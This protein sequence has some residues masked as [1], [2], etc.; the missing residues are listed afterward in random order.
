MAADC[1]G[2]VLIIAGS[3]PSGGAGIQAD[4]KTVT[5]LGGYASAAVSALTVQNTVGVQDVMAVPSAFVAGQITA[6]LDDIGA[7]VVKT[8]MLFDAATI[9]AVGEAL[10]RQAFSGQLV[11]DPVMVATSG[12]SLLDPDAV[13]A[14][15]KVLI[16]EGALVTPN[17]PEASALTGIDIETPDDMAA[18]ADRLIEMGA[19]AA[20]VK[21][22]H[23]GGDQLMDLLVSADGT[24]VTIEIERIDSRHTHG[25]GCTMASALATCL[26]KGQS[27]ESAFASAHAF[28][29]RAIER[30]PGFGSG[31]GPMGHAAAGMSE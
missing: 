12:D 26:A 3:D 1:Q 9:E 4:I 27:L 23:L 11:V 7:D 17:I 8:G 10:S 31:N 2:R 5:A 6:V 28:V 20:L 21:G 14:L 13:S 19:G 15:K 30:A 29:R 25:T 22:G 18:A 24:S 16:S